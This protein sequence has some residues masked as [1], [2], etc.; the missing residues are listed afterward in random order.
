MPPDVQFSIACL[1]HLSWDENLFQ[2][3]QQVMSRLARRRAVNYFCQV[4]TR[5]FWSLPRTSTLCHAFSPAAN[6]RV[7]YLP[8]LPMTGRSLLVRSINRRLYTRKVASIVKKADCRRADAGP[9]VLWLYHPKDVRI[10]DLVQPDLVVYDC[11]DEFRAFMHS[12]PETRRFEQRLLERADVVFAGGR[13]L[14]EAKKNLNLN[15]HLFPCGVDFEHFA[16]AT[17]PDAEIADEM[18]RIPRPVIGYIGAVDERLDYGLLEASAGAHPEWSFVLI[19][20]LLKVNPER[21]FGMLNVFYLG[22]KP[23]AELPKL[24]K[25]FD[26]AMMPFAI[27]DLTMK[28]SPTKTLEYLSAALPVVSSRVPDVLADYPDLVEF[29]DSP[30]SFGEAATRCLALSP[31][32]KATLQNAAQGKSWEAMVN[33]MEGIAARKLAGE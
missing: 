15:V 9:L 6:V 22:A 24:M 4:P 31:E 5:T 33:G 16:K 11:M 8:F 21:L 2:R 27:T 29:Y 7:F 32:R 20:P 25:A 23:Y 18:K 17:A 14:F 1:S 19:G 26:V 10:L 28:I 30:A 12:E 3:P 13:S